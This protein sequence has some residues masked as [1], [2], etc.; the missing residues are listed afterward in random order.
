MLM[1]LGAGGFVLLVA[2]D[3]GLLGNDER[4]RH[5]D[6]CGLGLAVGW[7][8]GNHLAVGFGAARVG[9]PCLGLAEDGDADIAVQ[10]QM[11]VGVHF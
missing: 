4:G 10:E 2:G 3:A 11:A 5:S 8:V 1:V 9:G 7:S 6:L